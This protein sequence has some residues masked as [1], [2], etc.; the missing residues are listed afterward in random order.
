M[1]HCPFCQSTLIQR[2]YDGDLTCLACS[3]TVSAAP[4]GLPYVKA[5]ELRLGR[6]PNLERRVAAERHALE[7]VQRCQMCRHLLPVSGFA[8]S[9]HQGQ[10]RHNKTCIGCNRARMARH[11]A[12]PAAE[13]RRA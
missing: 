9:K 13:A 2:E 10:L 11:R 5:G 4:V 8:L 6:G 3:R 12:A 1:N 7:D